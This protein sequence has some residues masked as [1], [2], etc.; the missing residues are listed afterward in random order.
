[1]RGSKVF[2]VLLLFLSTVS[3][4]TVPPGWNIVKDTKGLCQIA[5]PPEWTSFGENTGAAVFRDSTNAIAVV[6]SQSGQAFK[7]LPDPLVRSLEIPKDRMFENTPK[8][9]FYQDRVSKGPEDTNAY[10]SSVPAKSG[11]CSCH[12]VVL[13][14]VPAEVA[15]KIVMTLGPVAGDA[16]EPN[17]SL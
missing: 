3:A 2:P 10:S 16:P 17:G 11:T 1:M 7:P 15:K 9:I 5:V 12:L 8:R 14:N 13:P 4:Q 6:T